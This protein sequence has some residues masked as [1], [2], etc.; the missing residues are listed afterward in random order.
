MHCL[1]V[2]VAVTLA[3]DSLAAQPAPASSIGL[4]LP[5]IGLPLQVIGLP[6]QPDPTPT[7]AGPS[8]TPP[9]PVPPRAV[10]FFGLAPDA[11][12]FEPWQQSL[13]PGLVARDPAPALA[14]AVAGEMAP[15]GRL[16]LELK[17]A[18]AQLFIDG[19]FV[20]TWADHGGELDLPAGTRRLEV[21]A[22]SHESLTVDIRI[23]AGREVTYR[24]ALSRVD[25][26][27]NVLASNSALAPVAA[28][29]SAADAPAP[30][31][32]FYLIPGCYLGNVPP[33]QVKLPAN[34]DLSRMITHTPR[35]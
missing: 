3:A 34:C 25:E 35:R 8:L 30:P 31:S 12:G 9:P 17:P 26:R 21:R 2:I 23:V 7:P 11:W 20:G 19:E 4:P 22:P 16:R 5:S 1:G 28:A 29:P 27:Q 10:V 14:A 13:T 32:T 18:A 6:P 33:D 15:T 24:G